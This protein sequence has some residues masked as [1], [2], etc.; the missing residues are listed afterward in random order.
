MNRRIYYDQT[1]LYRILFGL[2]LLLTIVG[3]YTIRPVQAASFNIACNDVTD[4]I[5]A[6]NTANGNGQADTITLAQNCTYTLTAVD[7]TTDGPAG[8]PIISSDITVAGNGA[9]I[10]RGSTVPAFRLLDMDAGGSLTLQNLTLTNGQ[11]DGA[12]IVNRGG[13][14]NISGST[15]ANNVGGGVGAIFNSGTLT[16]DQSTFTNNRG[17]NAGAMIA[18]GVVRITRSTFLGNAATN[19]DGGAIFASDGAVITIANSTFGGN[20]AAGYGGTL[21]T[22]AGSPTTPPTVTIVNSTFVGNSAANGGAIYRFTGSVTLQ[23]TIIANSTSGGNCVNTNSLGNNLSSDGSCGGGAGDL[24]NTNPLLGSLASNGGATQTYAL[25]AGSPAL[26]VGNAG[27]CAAAPVNNIDQRGVTRPQGAVCD[28]GAYE[29]TTI[30]LVTNT[31]D[32]GA[33]SLRQAI[34]D[35]NAHANTGGPDA[36]Y[37]NIPGAGVHTIQPASALPVVIDPI[38]MDGATQPG[39]NCN[40]WP[41]TL[42]IELDGTNAGSTDGL[43]ISGGNSTVRGLI[44]NRFQVDGIGIFSSGGNT[45]QCN[46]VGTDSTGTSAQKNDQGGVI[47]NGQ[48]NNIIG[49]VSP[50][51]GNVISANPYAGISLAAAD[52]NVVQGNYL[53]TNPTGAALVV[54]PGYYPNRGILLTGGNNLIGGPDPA[55]RNIIVS[56]LL[57]IDIGAPSGSFNVIQGNYIGVDASG[58]VGLGNYSDGVAIETGAHDNKLTANVIASNQGHGIN[59]HDATSVNNVIQGNW[60]GTDKTG[61]VSLPNNQDGIHIDGVAGNI[62]GG[63][64]VSQGNIIAHNNGRGIAIV[65]TAINNPLRGNAIFANVSLGIDLGADGV[66]FNHQGSI[67]GPNNYQNYPVLT[68]ATTDGSSVHVKGTLNSTFNTTFNIELFTNPTCDATAFGEGQIFIGTF[69]VTTDGSGKASFDQTLAT[70]VPE[71]QGVSATATDPSNNTSEFSYC[72]PTTTTNLNWQAA[73]LLALSSAGSGNGSATVQQRITDISQEKWFKFPVQPGDKVHIKLTALPGSAVSLHLDPHPFYNSLTNPQSAAVLSAEAAD[74]AFLPS[75]SLPSQSLP[76]QSLPSQSLPTGALLT[77]F[78]PSQSLPSQSLPSQSLPSQSLP[79]QSL[80]SQSLPSQSLPSGALPSGSLPSQSLP[81]QSLPS[82]SLPSQSLPVGFL[83]EAYSG[84]ARRSLMAISLDPYATVQTIDRNTYDIL[85]D[86]YARVVGPYDP[87]NPFTLEVTIEGGVC[88]TIQAIPDSLPAIANP[89]AGTHKTLILTHSGRLVGAPAEIATT[90]QKLQALAGRPD[91]DGVVIDLTDAQYQRVAFAN[92]QA[93]QNLACP[94]AKN[95]VAA[96][97]K[98]IINSYRAA[99]VAGGKTTLQYIVLAGGANT[100]PF[101]QVPDVAGLASEKEYVVPVKASTASE[102]GLKTGLV[103]GQDDYGTQ[104]DLA[105]GDHTFAVPDLAVGR[106]VETAN[107]ISAVIDAYIATNGVV[108]PHSSLVTGYDFVGDAAAAIKVEADAGTGATADALI[109]APGLPPSD[110]SAW[111]ADNLRAKLFGSRHDLVVLSGHFSAGNL[112]AADYRTSLTAAEV[113]AS[114]VDF[115]NALVLT[116]G[117]HGGYTIPNIDQLSGASPD[118]DWA[119]AFLRKKAAGYIA[120]TGYAYGD[121]ELTEYGERLFVALT[122][123]LRTGSGPVALGQALIAAKQRYL[124]QTAQINGI[125]EKTLVEM[126]LYGLPMMKVNMPGQRINPT[127]DPSIVSSASLVTA[128]PGV[129]LGLRVGQPTG[130]AVTSSLTPH[131]V[132]LKN[133]TDNSTVATTYLSGKDGVVANPFAPIFPKEVYNVSLNGAVLR[134]IAFRGG[135]YTDQTGVIPLTSA[136]ATETSRPHLSFNADV[137]YPSQVWLSNYFDAINGGAARLVAVPG[138]FKSSAPGAID[139]TLRQF[140]DMKLNLYYLDANWTTGSATVKAAAVAAGPT[141][142]G[143]SGLVT[144][145]SVK[146]SVNVLG[147]A[148]AGI[149]AVWILYTGKSGPFYGQWQPLDLAQTNTAL[150]P[151]LWEGIL[152]LNGANAQDLVFMVQAVNGAGLTTLATNLGAYYSITPAT[153]PPRSQPALG[154]Q[155]PPTSGAYLRDSSFTLILTDPAT[156]QP[157]ANQL[158]TVSIGGQAAQATTDANGSATITI[159]PGLLPGTYPVQA[160]FRG[161]ASYLATSVVGS[162]TVVKDNTTIVLSPQSPSLVAVV[163]DSA[164]RPLNE[165]SVLFVVSG[166]GQTF[167][168][169]VIADLYGN[170]PLGDVP[171]PPGTYTVDAYFSG[172]ISVGNGQTVTLNDDTYQPSHA[173]GTL[174]I[175]AADTTAPSVTVSFP[176]PPAI[177]NG[178]FNTA[179]AANGIVGSVTAND[180]A[181]GASN[182]TAITCSGAVVGP[183]TGLGTGQASAALT[184]TAEGSHA[185]SC[186]ATDSAN[187]QG[188]AAGSSNTA[189][190]KIDKTAPDTTIVAMPTNPDTS[191][192]ATF[193]FNGNDGSGSGVVSFACRLENGN[194]AP[195]TSPQTYTTLLNGSHTFTVRALDAAGNVDATPASYT[196][197]ISAPTATPTP[198]NTATATPIP[199]TVTPTRTPSGPTPTPTKTP[200]PPT[201]TPTATPANTLVGTCGPYTVYRTGQGQYVAAGWSGTILVGTNGADNLSGGSSNDLILGLGGNDKLIGGSGNDVLCGN[202]GADTLDGGSGS[203]LLIGGADNDNLIGGSDNDILQGDGGNDTLDAGSGNDTLTGGSGADGFNGGSGTDRATDF[204]PAQGDKNNGGLEQFGAAS[205]QTSEQPAD[206][207]RVRV[208][209]ETASRF[210]FLPLVTK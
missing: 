22:T 127:P 54:T 42:Q 167:V 193:T 77:G 20:S 92:N 9:I 13:T 185:V 32:S 128:G 174:T 69:P 58:A 136:P 157:L 143:A 117:C 3:H 105:R 37:F 195:C 186:T 163:R 68:L 192:S 60:I 67:T 131:T 86:M 15:I 159:Q 10:M 209:P 43:L 129:A 177:Q 175:N 196:W 12:A 173:T 189:T 164:N 76:S 165:K 162:F 147:E 183:I 19:N 124:A 51:M 24:I 168:R 82:Q 172:V 98:R 112:L 120:A 102:A 208:T 138:Q 33:G 151:T 81:S 142:L 200:I 190:V 39:A 154:L 199:P 125:D 70:S 160:T 119:K 4:L 115:T 130:G 25:L 152:P 89:P 94:T 148:A 63:T 134:G 210:I 23:N 80:P 149:Q 56:S 146:F 188:A 73:Q 96:E 139:G 202:D 114:A 49:G 34:L 140:N 7:N 181:T 55:M 207:A 132:Q 126:T 201:A 62:I 46:F 205:A 88:S 29:Q 41:P 179:D 11:G 18:N 101:F 83:P 50:G 57:G 48:S 194:F 75:Q 53:G 171:L 72:H 123:Q 197:M 30:F 84:A 16:I 40:V 26:N 204:T 180:T 45:I 21:V 109:Q 106:L 113:G 65:N 161:S 110:P 169:S 187:N 100:I 61:T 145:N 90:I 99:N 36:I 121:T 103:Q 8:L 108:T 116:L 14:L 118:P 178:W 52:N 64:L 97:I 17:L 153:P 198:T 158:V 1:R 78:L 150:D 137:F 47:L 166:N 170:A 95:M 93:D 85:G 206:E 91:V 176:T 104:T 35:A 156:G 71:G 141:I 107:D 203:D 144:G 79:S 44:V 28:I 6:I 122:Q 31:N 184:V 27:A 5:A 155:S 182:I 135:V 111:T 87:A 2:I 66:T 191:T 74:T 38:I 133:L 59:I